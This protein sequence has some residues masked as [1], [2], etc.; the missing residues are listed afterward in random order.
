MAKKADIPPRG[1]VTAD[2]VAR[3][4]GVSRSAVSRTFTA[5]ASVSARTREK[6]TTAA[7][8]LGYRVNRF[9]RSLISEE[10]HLVGVVGAD[11]STPFISAMLDH[12]S[13][14]LL[15]QGLQ[16]LLLN[17]A[18][19][20]RNVEPLIASMLEFRVRAIILMSGTPPARIVDECVA[21][22]VPLVM[23]NREDLGEAET[24]HS[25]D[26]AGARLAAERLL[27]AGCKRLA[28]VRGRG[29]P[30]QVS[31]FNAFADYVTSRGAQVVKWSDG[32][33]GYETGAAAARSLLQDRAI[34]GAFCVTDL[35]AL[36]FLDAARHEL[37]RAVPE[38][39]SVIG[40]DDIPQA[41]W[42]AYRLT[43]IVQPLPALTEAVM[44]AIER[45]GGGGKAAVSIV[46]VELRERATVRR[47]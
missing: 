28:V 13:A 1:F 43:T 11:L 14:A 27:A 18:D 3:Q 21:N 10:S 37:G 6:V 19:A 16:C 33:T 36:G 12:F 4:A 31:R 2:D 23:V 8:E 5:G 41:G 15:R 24:I 22:G 26:V 17:A 25:D 39:L 29:T 9:A 32:P 40:F 44:A 35:L 38:T 47:S 45:G 34:D 46:P 30:A 7:A 42:A 20:G